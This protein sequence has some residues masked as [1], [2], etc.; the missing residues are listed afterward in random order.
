[1]EF[2]SLNEIKNKRQI[3]VFDPTI[4]ASADEPVGA[5]KVRVSRLYI[6]LTIDPSLFDLVEQ[7]P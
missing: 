4:W 2:H 7:C 3:A 6:S 5:R 1:M